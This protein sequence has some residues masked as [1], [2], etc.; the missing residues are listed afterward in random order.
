[1]V[2]SNALTSLLLRASV[3]FAFLYAALDAL[4]EPDA[5]LDYLPQTL[6]RIAPATA[7]LQIFAGLE[8]ILALWILSGK[9]IFYASLL[10]ALILVIIV[11]F[12]MLEF[13]LLFRDLSIA[14]AAF[15][16]AALPEAQR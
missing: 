4:V 6:T 3:A 2:R 12:N 11:L 14:A 1:M 5:W 15:A 7:E 10:A 8:I 13:Q 16:L 9:K